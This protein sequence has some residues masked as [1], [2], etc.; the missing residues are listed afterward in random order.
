MVK[1]GTLKLEKGIKSVINA[2]GNR[3]NMVR[4]VLQNVKIREINAVE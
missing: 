1:L 2:D 3:L 4:D